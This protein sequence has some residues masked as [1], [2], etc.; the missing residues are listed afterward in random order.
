MPQPHRRRSDPTSITR[1]TTRI[2][3][4]GRN[5]TCDTRFRKPLLSPLSYEGL[6]WSEYLR[7]VMRHG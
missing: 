4:P 3:A 5:R 2:G 6:G 7:L 1:N